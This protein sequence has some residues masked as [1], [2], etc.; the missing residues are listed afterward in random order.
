MKPIALLFI[1]SF[2]FV[3]CSSTI[4]MANKA[5][6]SGIVGQDEITVQARLGIPVE[7][8]IFSDGG[9]VFVYEY[10]SRVRVLPG[11]IESSNFLLDENS[12]GTELA[13]YLITSVLTYHPNSADYEIQTNYMDVYLDAEGYCIGFDHNLTKEQLQILRFQFE[14]YQTK[15]P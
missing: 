9:K 1:L 11:D 3:A 12:K 8:I 7:E 5:I 6:K 15:P 4:R 10:Y 14:Q 13:S 2:C